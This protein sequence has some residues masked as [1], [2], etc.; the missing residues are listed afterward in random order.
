MEIDDSPIFRYIYRNFRPK[1]HLE[2]GTW[3]GT[4]ILY[5]LEEC[6]ATVWTINILEG[7]D[8]ADGNIAY[9]H[10]PDELP[11]IHAWARK[12]G[13]PEK[14][15]YR[16][17]SIGFIGRFYLEKCLG[18]RVCQIYCDS[19]NWDIS[20][21][22]DG[23]FDTVLID[24][25]HQEDIVINDTRKGLKL[26]RSGGIIMW[27]DFCP[28]VF[29]QFPTT[30]GVMEAITSGWDFIKSSMEKIFWIYPSWILLGIKK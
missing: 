1:R 7:E 27:H 2:F 22:P 6:D 15:N 30:L 4:G 19:R 14:N 17:D 11:S 13:F 28:P 21:Y 10:Y 8:K 24:G 9:S 3:Q 20:N 26:L 23:F 18:H 25:G 29:Q 16:T 12:I 5:C